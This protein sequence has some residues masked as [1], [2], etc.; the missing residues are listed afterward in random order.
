MSASS[1]ARQFMAV[2]DY[3]DQYVQPLILSALASRLPRGS[4]TLASASSP[5]PDP[6]IPCLHIRSYEELPFEEV[7]KHPMSCLANAYIIR[8]ALIR[9]HYLN[10]TVQ[11]W[12]TKNPSS[13]LATHVKPSCDFELDYAE[14]LDDALVEAW[15]LRASF[16]KNE[17]RKPAER[18][19]WILKPSMSDRGQGIRLFSTQ[20]E[21]QSIFDDWEA[22]HPYADDDLGDDGVP[23]EGDAIPSGD[24]IMASQLRHFVTQPYIHPPLLLPQNSHKFH[25]RTYVLAV[26]GLKV[27]VYRHMLALFASTPYSAPWSQSSTA[28]GPC[29]SAHLTNTCLQDGT[30]EG[31]VQKFW[32]LPSKLPAGVSPIASEDWR[33]HVFS[34]IC[35]TTGEVFEAAARTTVVHFQTLPNAFEVFGLDFLVD[36]ALTPWLLEVNAFPDFGQTGEELKGLVGGLWEGVVDVAISSFFGIERS[37]ECRNDDM[38]LVRD[39]DLGRRL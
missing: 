35:E 15:E 2:V 12:I 31:S 1:K 39:L 6:C 20:A 5:I 8:K 36:A 17:G 18:E 11:T 34:Q 3:G 26:G 19:W 13:V 23:V 30:R 7:T 33:S 28:T 10:N 37:D 38:V 21:L 32:S 14:F 29:L 27:Y 22:E 9:K 4:Y 16:C 24:C 25:I